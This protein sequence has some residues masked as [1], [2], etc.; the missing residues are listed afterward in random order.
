MNSFHLFRV[1]KHLKDAIQSELKQQLYISYILLK[2]SQ[3]ANYRNIINN[4]EALLDTPI[5]KYVH[6]YILPTRQDDPTHK[7]IIELGRNDYY[8]QYFIK[9]K[10]IIQPYTRD[11]VQEYITH[12]F[13]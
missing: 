9:I 11:N 1:N 12:E 6:R 13:K 5:K 10:Q 4:V 7:V 3:Y 8:H 2:M